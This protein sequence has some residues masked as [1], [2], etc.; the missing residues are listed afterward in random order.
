MPIRTKEEKFEIQLIANEAANEICDVVSAWFFLENWLS[1]KGESH[2]QGIKDTSLN[3]SK[4][5]SATFAFFH[6][7][8]CTKYRD[9]F[10]I[11]L[12]KP[13]YD[14]LTKI[15][16]SHCQLSSDGF[17]I[18]IKEYNKNQLL[19]SAFSFK[20]MVSQDLIDNM[21]TA[22]AICTKFQFAL[23]EAKPKPQGGLGWSLETIDNYFYPI[24]R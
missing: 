12:Q 11:F 18:Y 5:K 22:K 19:I 3:L 8:L 4:T 7:S 15:G 9:T 17:T 16:V 10:F 24:S 14:V 21:I 20:V 13:M 2:T 1:L 6:N 23:I